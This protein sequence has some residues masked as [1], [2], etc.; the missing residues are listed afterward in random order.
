ML[1]PSPIVRSSGRAGRCLLGRER[2]RSDQRGHYDGV[3][4][5][6]IQHIRLTSNEK[7][8]MSITPHG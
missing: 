2:V 6:N 7:A 1:R 8:I 5:K 4:C 3:W